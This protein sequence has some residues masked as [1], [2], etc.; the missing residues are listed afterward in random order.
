[1]LKQQFYGELAYH[2]NSDLYIVGDVMHIDEFFANNTNIVASNFY[3]VVNLR[4]GYR[5]HL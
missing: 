5:G 1:M 3:T 4:S 2:H